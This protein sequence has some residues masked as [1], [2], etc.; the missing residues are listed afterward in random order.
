MNSAGP[1]WALEELGLAYEYVRLDRAK[2]EHRSAEYL[3]INP[4]GKVPALV[5]G[6]R[7]RFNRVSP[8]KADL[9]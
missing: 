9:S 8:S 5:D 3:A 4:N 2:R 6:D 1:H 7:A